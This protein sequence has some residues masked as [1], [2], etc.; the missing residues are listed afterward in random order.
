MAKAL[1]P[2]FDKAGIAPVFECDQPGITAT[3]Q[4]A[5]DVE[6][7]FAANATH[8][9]ENGHPN[10]ALKA[11]EAK[12]KLLNHEPGTMSMTQWWAAS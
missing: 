5:G 4:A 8:D 1:K 3:R 7:F 11:V 9:A 6:Y 12:I 10:T 2:H